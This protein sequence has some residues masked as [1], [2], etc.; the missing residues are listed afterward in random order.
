MSPK[1][2]K[3]EKKEINKCIHWKKKKDLH[4]IQLFLYH[5]I[6]KSL[7]TH[8][9]FF[10]RF[11]RL[12]KCSRVY[13]IYWKERETVSFGT[14]IYL[15]TDKQI[16]RTTI[17]ML[18]IRNKPKNH[19]NVISDM[20]KDNN[21]FSFFLFVYYGNFVLLTSLCVLYSINDLLLKR[22]FQ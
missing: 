11:I 18:F 17:K 5:S 6:M 9:Y 10:L 22:H 16:Y 1:S 20:K 2:M 14:D 12:F 4:K 8:R 15:K 13:H 21:K 19:F 7:W 3:C